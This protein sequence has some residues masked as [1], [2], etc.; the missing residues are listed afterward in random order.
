MT[1]EGGHIAAITDKASNINPLWAPPW[2]SIE[3]SSYSPEMHPEYGTNSES[4][5]LA[6]I[7][8]HNLCLD[9]FGP[10]S[11]DESEAGLTVHGEGSVVRYNFEASGN[12]VRASCELPLAQLSFARNLRL[13]GRK[14]SISENVTNRSPYDR[15]VAWQQHVT[16]GP[17]FLERGQ[18]QLNAPVERAAVKDTEEIFE[19]PRRPDGHDLRT[20]TSA[21]SSGGYT[22]Q[23][24]SKANERSWFLAFSPRLHLLLAYSWRTADFPWLGIWDE[25]C[26]RQ[27]APWNGKTITLGLEFGTTP[28]PETRRAMIERGSLFGTPAYRWLGAGKTATVEYEAALLPIDRMPASLEKLP[29][30]LTNN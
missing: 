13:A 5:L 21:A 11:D 27:Q 25:N 1:V 15:P 3:P 8:G 20:F 14:I 17:P 19:W 29:E 26:S 2:K 28:F 12:E 23:L 6:G 22:A 30:S 4:K 24:L 9:L 7:L 16:L 18:T 10:P